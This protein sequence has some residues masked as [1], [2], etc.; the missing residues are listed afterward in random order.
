[1]LYFLVVLCDTADSGIDPISGKYKASIANADSDI[2]S[3]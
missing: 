3:L 2:F 1:M